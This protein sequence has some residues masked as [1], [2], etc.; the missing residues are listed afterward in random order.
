MP[1]EDFRDNLTAIIN[2]PELQAH[3]PSILLVT[4]PPIDEHMRFAADSAKGFNKKLRRTQENTQK[5]ADICH[6]LG[7]KY[8]LPVADLWKAC[9]VY[10]G[11]KEG[12]ELIGTIPLPVNQK[13]QGL[14]NDGR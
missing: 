14:F 3:K 11:W 13:F 2:H 1:L 8:N 9:M 10:G 7:E 12:E 6:E 5:Y 4:P